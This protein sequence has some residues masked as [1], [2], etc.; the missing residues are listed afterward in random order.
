[1]VGVKRAEGHRQVQRALVGEFKGCGCPW[2]MQQQIIRLGLKTLDPR[3]ESAIESASKIVEDRSP[4]RTCTAGEARDASFP[5]LRLHS[6][7]E[8]L[9]K[10]EL[11][12]I[13]LCKEIRDDE[14]LFSG[15]KISKR[16]QRE[17]SH[18]KDLLK[19]VEE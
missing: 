13:P 5:N 8:Y 7:Q 17:L 3:R 4:K 15:M 16:E 14:A 11:Q 10:R 12:Q 19:L 6:R 18:K 2:M 1:M 9:T